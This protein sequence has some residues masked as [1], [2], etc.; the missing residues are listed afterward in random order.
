MKTQRPSLSFSVACLVCIPASIAFA[1]STL[2]TSGNPKNKPAKVDS[3]IRTPDGQFLWDA[4]PG[5]IINSNNFPRTLNTFPGPN[6]DV[7]MQQCFGGGFAGGLNTSINLFTMTAAANWNEY[8]WNSGN[9]QVGYSNF[10]QSWVTSFPRPEGLYTHYLDATNGAAATTFPQVP[11]DPFGPN[12]GNRNVAKGYF[13][14]P[15]FA[16][17]D[18]TLAGGAVNPAGTNNGRDVVVPNT[19]AL[20][21]APSNLSNGVDTPRFN[22]NISR[23]YNA[24]LGIGIPANQIIVLY[25]NNAVNTQIGCPVNGPATLANIVNASK[26]GTGLY[27]NVAGQ[28][29]PTAPNAN[30]HLFVYVSGHGS[31]WDQTGAKGKA[32]TAVNPGTGKVDVTVDDMPVTTLTDQEGS[33]SG[34]G[35]MDLQLYSPATDLAGVNLSI[36]GVVV[37][38]LLSD[39]NPQDDL[40]NIIGSTNTYD[41]PVSLSQFSLLW[42]PGD[43]LTVS[44]ENNLPDPDAV[45]NLISAVSFDAYGDTWSVGVTVPEPAVGVLLLA[46]LACMSRHKRAV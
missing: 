5:A 3:Y 23:V 1:Q 26:N 39:P 4:D 15:V 6:V 33:D 35:T 40:S 32:T 14:N 21:M 36:N 28:N 12:G 38:S 46:G 34:V 11:P 30:S 18:P 22:V 25:G 29:A 27:G 19:Y 20:L 10:T 9:A 37:G 31:S 44:L 7:V 43:P 16:S 42:N 17:P 24:L 45:D 41:V 2:V 13:E 8:A